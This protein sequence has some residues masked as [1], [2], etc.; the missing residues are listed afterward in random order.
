MRKALSDVNRKSNRN[1]QCGELALIGRLGRQAFAKSSPLA[2]W[3]TF[4]ASRHSCKPA[5]RT[6]VGLARLHGIVHSPDYF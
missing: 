4:N 2:W 3:H 1:G 6:V 5:D